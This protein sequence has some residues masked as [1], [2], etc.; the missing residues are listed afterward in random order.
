MRADATETNYD[1][2]EGRAKF[3]ETGIGKDDS[4]AC[5]LFKDQFVIVVSSSGSSSDLVASGIF[6]A[7]QRGWSSGAVLSKLGIEWSAR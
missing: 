6:F 5:K 4:V 7:C 1:D 2:D 3:G